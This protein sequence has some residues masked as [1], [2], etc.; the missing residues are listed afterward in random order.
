M[1]GVRDAVLLVVMPTLGFLIVA[2]ILHAC[3]G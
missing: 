3:I 1:R 2:A